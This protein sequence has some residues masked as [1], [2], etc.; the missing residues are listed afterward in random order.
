MSSRKSRRHRPQKKKSNKKLILLAA[1][2][3]FIGLIAIVAAFSGGGHNSGATNEPVKVRL[4]T[5]IGNI[6]IKLRDDM[7]ITTA[8]FVNLTQQGVYDNTI[9][10]R[11]VNIPGDLVIIQ[12][13]D[14]TGTGY[15]D[16]SIPSIIDEFSEN[17]EHNKNERGTI[18]MAN[19][20]AN[21]GSS[22][23][24]I[25]G[26]YNSHLDNVHP[27]FGDVIEGMDVVDEILNVQTDA[28]S[29]PI[30]DVILISATIVD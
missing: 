9:F 3:A 8:N 20:G 1:F 15:G 14:P 6:V 30:E 4:E 5:S 21:T 19:A 16:P 23:F 18:A 2:F 27:V 13:G 26:E 29:K 22:Q 25:N 11:V 7:P 10:H 17:P 28:D 12:G 24:F